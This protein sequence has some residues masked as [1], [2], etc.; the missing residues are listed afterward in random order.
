MRGG[1]CRVVGAV[2]AVGWTVALPTG[3]A[4]QSTVATAAVPWLPGEWVVGRPA[5][6]VFAAAH[7]TLRD[8]GFA[9]ERDDAS[10]GVL[11]TRRVRYRASWPDAATLDL[12]TT[13][14]P[15]AATLY[16]RVAPGFEPAR[17][18]V[19][20]VL[21]TKTTLVPLRG[22]KAQ[23]SSTLYGHLPLAAATAERIAAR[24]G[25]TLEPLVADP[26]ER[27]KQVARLDAAGAASCGPAVLLPGAKGE[28]LPKLTQDVKP[29]YPASELYSGVE[30]VV[31]L[32]GEV[33]EHGT[34]MGVEW[35]GGRE[36]PNLVAAAMGAASLWR[37]TAPVVAGCPVRRTVT[38]QMSFTIRR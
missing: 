14:T 2:I 31:L 24:L 4:G 33:T 16:V 7:A 22:E 10:A 15:E 21:D 8:M 3:S 29:M 34:L 32:R 38:I 28:P 5:T 12:S 26:V 11:V 9:F 37:F 30:G 27:S 20:A 1:L 6:E 25:V 17:L 36:E 13:R 23:G 18:A 35:A 19:G